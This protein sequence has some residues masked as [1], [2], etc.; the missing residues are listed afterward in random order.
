LRLAYR[1]RQFWRALTA[2]PNPEELALAQAVLSPEL[3]ALFLRL[4]AS[5]QVHALGMLRQLSAHNGTHPDLVV[6]V[7]LHDVGKTRCPLH[8]WERGIIVLGEVLLPHKVVSWSRAE[9]R[10]WKRPFVVAEQHAAWGA[11]LAARAGASSLAVTLIRRHHEALRPV[12]PER[13][14]AQQPPAGQSATW[15]ASQEDHLLYRLQ[16]L[17][18]ES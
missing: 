14:A 15:Q 1:V 5:E 13:F 7:L 11:E 8:L 12:L 6:A 16:Q 2:V 9:A 17:D 10:G 3:M 4:Q 18:E